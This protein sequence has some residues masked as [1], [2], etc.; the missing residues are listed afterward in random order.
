MCSDPLGRIPNFLKESKI[1]K[2]PEVIVSLGAL[3]FKKL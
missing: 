2:L 1:K 3:L